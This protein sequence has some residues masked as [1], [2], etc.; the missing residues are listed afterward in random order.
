MFLKTVTSMSAKIS[1]LN[2]LSNILTQ[3]GQLPKH[4]D[5]QLAR[6]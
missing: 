5:C 3:K 2:E 6:R 4:D 1:I